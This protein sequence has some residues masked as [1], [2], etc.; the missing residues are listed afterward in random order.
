[1]LVEDSCV[2]QAFWGGTGVGVGAD[3]VLEVTADRQEMG[4]VAARG[5]FNAG[6]R[7]LRE[8]RGERLRVDVA[9]HDHLPH[10]D[11]ARHRTV[12][13]VRL[14]RG[15]RDAHWRHR[16]LGRDVVADGTDTVWI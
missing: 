3:E 8:R 5:Q 13:A 4:E 9:A 7:A 16:R 6:V 14:S 12:G 1:M 11:P 2:S 15:S 10:R